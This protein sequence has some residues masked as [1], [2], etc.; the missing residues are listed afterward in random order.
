MRRTGALLAAVVAL[1]LAIGAGT[2]AQ[3]QAP[4]RIGA[5]LSQIGP[6]APLAL[7]PWSQHP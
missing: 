1:G 2:S 7:P 3:A 5:S 6:Y 4:L